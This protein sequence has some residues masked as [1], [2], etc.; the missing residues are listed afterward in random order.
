MLVDEI[1][2]NR[3]RL[4]LATPYRLSY[5]T[6]EAFEPLLVEAVDGQCG[7]GEVHI[8]PGCGAGTP[9]GGWALCRKPA[10]RLPGGTT[11]DA[12]AG[13]WSAT[14]VGAEDRAAL[15]RACAGTWRR[16]VFSNAVTWPGFSSPNQP[17]QKRTTAYGDS[18]GPESRSGAHCARIVGEWEEPFG[19]SQMDAEA[20]SVM[21]AELVGPN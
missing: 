11:A 8:S 3:I 9:A 10:A 6:V 14:P 17:E 4:P 21:T 19:D 12:K 5:R 13:L 20:A 1:R 7:C 16:D 18:S 2:L 15:M